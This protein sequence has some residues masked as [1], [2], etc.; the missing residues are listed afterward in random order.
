MPVKL[1]LMALAQMELSP[2]VQCLSFTRKACQRLW[3]GK[4][5][6]Q[7]GLWLY[8]KGISLLQ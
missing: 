6:S 7:A 1:L 5:E 2:L 4:G 8:P 3:S